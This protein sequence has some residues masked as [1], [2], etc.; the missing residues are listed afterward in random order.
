[1]ANPLAALR[2]RAGLSQGQLADRVGTSQ[3]QI[4]RIE[5]GLR[6]LSREWALRI[7][8]HLDAKPEELMFGDRTVPLVGHVGAGS[9]AHYYADSDG[10]IG[11]AKMPPGGSER[12]VSV[13]IKGDS[14][15][16]AL[17]GWYVYYDDR[18]D[19]PTDDLLDKLCVVGLASGQVLI[20]R[21]MRGRIAGRYDLWSVNGAP[22][23]DELVIWAA[24]VSSMM[25]PW[26]ARVEE[27][28][29]TLPVEQPKKR[30]K[31]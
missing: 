14:L 22:Q 17:D 10:E 28:Q 20:K 26:A 4:Q 18:R 31:K 21:L 3:P 24:P 16:A 5:K 8:P 23:T 12:T 6:G 9:E 29:E 1:M 2:K 15:G 13:R 25:P 30:R 19:P 7:A 11:R 27:S